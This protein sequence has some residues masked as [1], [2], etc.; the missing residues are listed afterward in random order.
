MSKPTIIEFICFSQTGKL[1]YHEDFQTNIKTDCAK[2]MVSDQQFCN[3][4]KTAFGVC[5]TLADVT[6]R[7]SMKVGNGQISKSFREY[8]TN[9]YK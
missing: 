5:H 7:I 3:R 1:I 8:I 4:M 9:A 2:K 6:E